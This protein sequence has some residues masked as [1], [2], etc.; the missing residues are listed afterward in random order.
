MLELLETSDSL[1]WRSMGL[2]LKW[3]W[4][5]LPVAD[6]GRAAGVFSLW[7]PLLYTAHSVNSRMDTVAHMFVRK[8][9]TLHSV[10]LS[11]RTVVGGGFIPSTDLWLMPFPEQVAL[12]FMVA[13]AFSVLTKTLTSVQPS[14]AR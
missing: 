9:T 14:E 13:C 8:H 4:V 1:A 10:M 7:Y 2:D 6:L 5:R 3:P 12:S 11:L